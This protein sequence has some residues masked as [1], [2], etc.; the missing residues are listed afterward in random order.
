LLGT[1]IHLITSVIFME[2]IV[3]EAINIG[4]ETFRKTLECSSAR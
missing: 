4:E 1:G 2:F 3:G